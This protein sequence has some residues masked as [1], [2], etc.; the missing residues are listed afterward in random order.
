MKALISLPVILLFST[1]SSFGQVELSE[2]MPIKGEPVTITLPQPRQRLMVR[3][4]P[5]S[6]LASVDT[7][8]S[9]IPTERF[10]WEARQ[11]GIARIFT[12]DASGQILESRNVSV[13]FRGVSTG[14]LIVMILAGCVLFGGVIFSFRILFQKDEDEIFLEPEDLEQRADT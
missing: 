7:L 6:S 8:Y 14:G 10:Q 12:E 13:R 9:E 1:L 4:R 11:A 5:N 3:Y 2:P